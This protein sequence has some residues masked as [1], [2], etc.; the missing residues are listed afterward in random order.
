MKAVQLEEYGSADVI[1]F[2]D[3]PKPEVLPNRVL[4]EVHAASVNPVDWKIMVGELKD[5][6]PMKFPMTMGGDFSGEIVAIGDGVKDFSI[7]E[8]VFGYAN[9]GRGGSG[10]FAEFATV[11]P[12]YIVRK[13]DNISFLEAA[14]LPMTGI[15]AWQV[16]VKYIQLKPEQKILLHGGGGGIGNLAIQIAKQIGAYV[17]TTCSPKDIEFVRSL[18]AD[19]VL[20]YKTTHFE[21][22]LQDF[23]A[24]FD[25]IGGETFRKSFQVLSKGG[26][27]VSMLGKPDQ[28][29][30]DRYDVQF[31]EQG[32][33][34]SREAFEGLSL[35]AGEAKIKAVID[36]VFPFENAKEALT[37]Q[38]YEHI[39]G[40][41]VLNIK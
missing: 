20:D 28:E 29:L 8:A 34:L 14:A 1:K 32:K 39:Q 21:E 4:V 23:D 15:R 17:A 13:P 3:I 19:K 16:L 40:K 33:E 30:L 37:K 38:Q 5:S 7:G 10:S 9:I 22:V 2:A 41:I 25:T 12:Q 26:V 24:V 36:E 11:D 27:I 35:L 31:L 18:G 6:M